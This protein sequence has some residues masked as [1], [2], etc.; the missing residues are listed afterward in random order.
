MINH[1]IYTGTAKSGAFFQFQCAR[2]SKNFSQLEFIRVTKSVTLGL[3]CPR[4]LNCVSCPPS[5]APQLT[6]GSGSPSRNCQKDQCNTAR[7]CRSLSLGA[8]S[9]RGGSSFPVRALTLVWFFQECWSKPPSFP[10]SF[11]LPFPK[12]HACCLITDMLY[13]SCWVALLVWTGSRSAL[14]AVFTHTNLQ[15]EEKSQVNGKL[16]CRGIST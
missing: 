2:G 6:G 3:L 10:S 12:T 13:L 7:G 14:K 1:R 5:R 9:V 16:F 4:R 8:I 15:P 11:K